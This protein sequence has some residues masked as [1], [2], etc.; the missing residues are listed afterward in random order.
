MGQIHGSGA[1]NWNNAT[2]VDD[3]LGVQ[4]GR[5]YV[6]AVIIDGQNVD[7]FSRLRTSS[8]NT[9]F[10]SKQ[11]FNNQP[12]FWDDQEVSG[13]ST[14]SNHSVSTASTVIG[15]GNNTAGIRRRQTYSYFNYQPGK[16][17]LILMTGI[18]NKSGGGSGI[19]QRLGYFD[20]NNGLFFENNNGI[21]NVVRRTNTSGTPV[22]NAVSQDN[23][24]ID[25]LDGAGISGITID[26]TKAQIFFIDFEWLGVGRTRFGFKDGKKILYCHEFDLANTLTTVTMSTPNLPLRYEI[27]NDGAGGEAALE[28]IC[29]SVISE[30][31]QQKTGILRHHH[32]G[33]LGGLNPGSHYFIEGIKLQSGLVGGVI[34]MESVALASTSANDRGHW[35]LIRNPEVL[36][37]TPTYS[38]ETN[39]TVATANG[40]SIYTVSGGQ[41]FDGGY[42]STTTPAKEITPN[43]LRLGQSITGSQD[44]FVLSFIPLTSNVTIHASL[45]WRELS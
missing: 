15:V 7:A 39:S 35:M 30:G 13:E 42:L 19:I 41:Q 6:N 22:D 10:D 1:G 43:A 4:Q 28:H 8:P 32:T 5:A 2:V 14:T 24:N 40:S 9:L 34:D 25:K 29:T 17:H 31:G 11:I 45:N 38:D 33:S 3:S 21:L 27:I 37:G 26:A 20:D 23:W 16:S 44:T 12:L 18:L 36:G